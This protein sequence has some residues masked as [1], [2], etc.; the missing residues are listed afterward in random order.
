MRT[1]TVLLVDDDTSHLKILEKVFRKADYTPLTATSGKQAL[2][3]LREQ[4]ADLIVTDLMMPN[5]NGVDLLKAARAIHPHVE[6]ILMTAFGSVER[7][8]EAMKE[9][10]SDFIEKPIKR[11]TIL[12]SAA[13][14]LERKALLSE[15]RALRSEIKV[16]R[17]DREIVGRSPALQHVLDTVKQVAPTSA[18]VLV[19]G[20][21]GTGK[22]L[23]A[24]AIHN[25]SPRESQPFVAVNCAALPESIIESELFGHEKGAYTGAHQRKPGRFEL[26]DNGTLFLDEIGEL[27]LDMQS[28]LLRVLQESELTRVGGT[29][30][31]RVDCRILAA[32]NKNLEQEVANGNFRADLFYRLAVITLDIPPLRDRTEDIPLLAEH[33]LHTFTAQHKRPVTGF[34]REALAAMTAYTWPGN[35]RELQ[36]AIERAVILARSEHI[37]IDALPSPLA[38]TT[39]EASSIHTD[40]AAPR[41]LIIPLGTPLDTIKRDVILETLRM[42]KGDKRLAAQ[43]LGIATRTIYRVLEA[44]AG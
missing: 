40:P 43:L 16:L 29:K 44:E 5:M 7:A 24:R 32:T 26:A 15:N 9:G 19:Q 6:V 39:S 2:D 33:F 10:A 27:H 11:A 1:P 4:S 41:N 8:V 14:A 3:R 23:I 38:R 12:K 30:P 22:E 13:K 36:N 25:L 35:V 34:T 28:K 31:I 18:T 42:C 17:S 37:D 21:S 20:A